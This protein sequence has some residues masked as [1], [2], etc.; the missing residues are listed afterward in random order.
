MLL[1]T[2]ARA[3]AFSVCFRKAWPSPLLAAAPSINPGRSATRTWEKKRLPVTLNLTVFFFYWIS[4]SKEG[5]H[6]E[7]KWHPCQYL[8]RC[9][10]KRWKERKST[11]LRLH[12]NVDLTLQPSRFSFLFTFRLTQ[13]DATLKCRQV[14]TL[15]TWEWSVYSTIPMLGRIVVTTKGK[16]TFWPVQKPVMSNKGITSHFVHLVTIYRK[17][18]G[19]VPFGDR[20]DKRKLL[21]SALRV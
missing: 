2:S 13:Q 19:K 6:Y 3:L 11:E 21:K 14:T 7:P 17:Y 12:S 1:T 16:V 18:Q 15:F 20:S 9:R 5:Q 4:D 8:A 10:W